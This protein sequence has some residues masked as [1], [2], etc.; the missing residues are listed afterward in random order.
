MALT[1]ANKPKKPDG[2]KPKQYPSRANV[3]YVG[4]SLDLYEQ[5]Q[6]IGEQEDRSAS[7]LARKAIREYLERRKDETE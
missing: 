6:Q 7:W 1:V 3:K 2:D 4:I 5:L